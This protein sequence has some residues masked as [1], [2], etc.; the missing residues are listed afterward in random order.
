MQ[1]IPTIKVLGYGR[2]SLHLNQDRDMW[3]AIICLWLTLK[4]SFLIFI[5]TG[6]HD[7][8]DQLPLS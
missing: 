5:G 8:Q 7:L 1:K 6:P 3:V 4:A 2:E